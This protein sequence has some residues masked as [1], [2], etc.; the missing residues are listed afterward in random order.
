MVSFKKGANVILGFAI[1]KLRNEIKI[2]TVLCFMTVL[3]IAAVV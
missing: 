3:I 2:C 1:L